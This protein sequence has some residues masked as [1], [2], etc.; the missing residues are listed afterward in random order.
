VVQADATTSLYNTEGSN[1]M[2]GGNGPGP[3][4]LLDTYLEGVGLTYNID[5]GGGDTWWRNNYNFNRDTFLMK[6][7]HMYQ[8]ANS[9]GYFYANRH[10]LE[11]KSGGYIAITGT[12]FDGASEEILP[13]AISSSS[14]A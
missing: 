2:I 4:E 5:D 14:P 10:M 11:W 1:F 12:I 7:S 3:N 9:D 8:T 13:P 6:T